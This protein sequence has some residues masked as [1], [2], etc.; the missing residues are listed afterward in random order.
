M[1]LLRSSE[2]TFCIGDSSS[3]ALSI[4]AESLWSTEI[5]PTI[6]ASYSPM[7]SK[8]DFTMWARNSPFSCCTKGLVN[9]RAWS[10]PFLEHSAFLE[11][12][13]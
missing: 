5:F 10:T 6:D 2:R 1:H 13:A 4:L 8:A 7:N 12:P 11:A 9:R 3:M